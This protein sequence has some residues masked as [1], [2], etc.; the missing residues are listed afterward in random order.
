MSLWDSHKV[1]DPKEEDEALSKIRALSPEQLKAEREAHLV[2]HCEH[3]TLRTAHC[4]WCHVQTP[5]YRQALA[6]AMWTV[7]D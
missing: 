6:D 2:T 1:T 7:L 5:A 4:P 3:G